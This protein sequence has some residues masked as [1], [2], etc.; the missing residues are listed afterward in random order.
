MKIPLE[1][2][3]EC[4]VY[5]PNWFKLGPNPR[6]IFQT[7]KNI[8]EMHE[9]RVNILP[10]NSKLFCIQKTQKSK[11]KHFRSNFLR[12]ISKVSSNN[13]LNTQFRHCVIS[14]IFYRKS[15]KIHSK[16]VRKFRQSRKIHYKSGDITVTHPFFH[17][18]IPEIASTST[19]VI[20]SRSRASSKMHPAYHPHFDK[21]CPA[22]Y[23]RA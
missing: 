8:Y 13:V 4:G 18:P 19:F 12:V 15:K 2:S 16:I 23:P 3:R 21:W 20:M 10:K 7:G 9:N 1:I 14:S 11:E 5:S 6:D 22:G 17:N